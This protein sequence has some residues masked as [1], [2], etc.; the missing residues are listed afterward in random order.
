MSSNDPLCVS[1]EGLIQAAS[2]GRAWPAIQRAFE[3]LLYKWCRSRAKGLPQADHQDIVQETYLALFTKH[4]AFNPRRGTARQFLLG[5]F[6]NAV[7]KVRRRQ[8]F[9]KGVKPIYL[10][11][12]PTPDHV[13]AGD[14]LADKRDHVERLVAR[15]DVQDAVRKLIAFSEETAPIEVTKAIGL[16]ASDD[17]LSLAQVAGLLGVNRTTLTRRLRVWAAPYRHVM[18][19]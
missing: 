19:Q 18:A 15:I 17:D 1:E 4:S 8:S 9:P 12:E 7:K 10:G 6:L 11:Q 13:A 14:S 2:D 16:L 3:P 5:L